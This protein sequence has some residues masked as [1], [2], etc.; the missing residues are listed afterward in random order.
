[1]R[2]L[3]VLFLLTSLLCAQDPDELLIVRLPA[4]QGYSNRH[5]TPLTFLSGR[6]QTASPGH[7]VWVQAGVEFEQTGAR[8]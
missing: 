8:R 3:G 1:M 7:E 4:K 6:S 2:C 5:A